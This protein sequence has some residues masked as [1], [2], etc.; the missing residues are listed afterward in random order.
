LNY[1]VGTG[2]MIGLPFQTV[3]DLAY[4]LDFFRSMDVDMVGMGPYI[5]HE[6]TPLYRFRNLL[7]NK[8]ERFALSLKMVAALRIIMPD[9]NIAATT[10][11][12]TLD[13]QGIE[14]A[15]IAGA[16]VV[17]PNI[18]P[19]KYRRNYLLYEDKPCLDEAVSLGAQRLER[20]ILSTGNEIGYDRWGD[21]EHFLKRMP[22]AD[23]GHYQD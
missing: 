2:V 3:D 16:N 14:K 7:L 17:M 9:V 21:A 20:R 12:E 1:Q 15:I 23:T 6:D 18:T 5:E 10:A 19:L 11:M 8:R 22:A 4:D 13:P